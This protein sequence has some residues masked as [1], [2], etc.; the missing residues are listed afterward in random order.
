[1]PRVNAFID[2]ET[3]GLNARF[4]GITQIAMIITVDGI[5]KDECCWDVAPFVEDNIDQKAL[6]VTNKTVQQ[7][8]S[9]PPPIVVIKNLKAIL[10][11]HVDPYN[12]L[13]K[14]HF[15]AYNSTFDNQFMREWFKKLNDRYFGSLFWSP[16]ICAM[17]LA[18]DRLAPIRHQLV[19][20][21]LETVCRAC[22]IDFNSEEAHDALYDTQKTVELYNVIK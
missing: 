5:V 18:A 1:M 20:F 4:N 19:N 3:T 11:K 7:I 22:G 2:V 8:Q 9:F 17:R 12:K 15:I 16:D 10:R 21:K 6:D 13:D 14:A